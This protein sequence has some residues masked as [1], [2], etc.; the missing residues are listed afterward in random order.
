M[1]YG[2]LAC[3]WPRIFASICE[4]GSAVTP[5]PNKATSSVECK[6][7]QR[8]FA[9][10]PFGQDLLENYPDQDSAFAPGGCSGPAVR[11]SQGRF[12]GGATESCLPIYQGCV[13]E[14][15]CAAALFTDIKTAFYNVFAEVALG[16]LLPPG[17]EGATFPKS[18]IEWSNRTGPPRTAG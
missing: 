1:S 16:R 14:R 5:V 8:R 9:G 7:C 3:G 6:E 10:V 18:K 11:R 13:K 2:V 12:N 17:N 4:A 15:K